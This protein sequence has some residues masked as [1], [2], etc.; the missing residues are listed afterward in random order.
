MKHEYHYEFVL[1]HI[2]LVRNVF[3]Y[4]FLFHLFS[5]RTKESKIHLT[6]ISEFSVQRCDLYTYAISGWDS[7]I[8]FSL[9]FLK[10][11]ARLDYK[12]QQYLACISYHPRNQIQ[13]I[14]VLKEIDLLFPNEQEK[15]SLFK[16]EI[17]IKLCLIDGKIYVSNKFK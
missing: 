15:S 8:I 9:H 17:K 7:H 16:V 4:H 1:R 6:S 11:F 14:K 12:C 2:Y 3:V 10:M 5:F 13:P